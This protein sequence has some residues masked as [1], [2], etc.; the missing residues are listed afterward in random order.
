[1]QQGPILPSARIV[2]GLVFA[3]ARHPTI[4]NTS[5]RHIVIA[6]S[7]AAQSQSHH[8]GTT[9]NTDSVSVATCAYLAANIRCAHHKLRRR[10]HHVSVFPRHCDYLMV[11]RTLD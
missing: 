2:V 6:T 5:Y 8:T 4:S 11:H 10:L 3:A 7:K 1:L 9:K